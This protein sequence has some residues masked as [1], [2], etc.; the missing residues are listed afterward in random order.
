MFSEEKKA[1]GDVL[2]ASTAGEANLP[3]RIAQ[4][5]SYSRLAPFRSSPG[6]G[7]KDSSFQTV[8]MFPDK[9]K[10]REASAQRVAE[11]MQLDQEESRYGTL[12]NLSGKFQII[13]NNL[14]AVPLKRVRMRQTLM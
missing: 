14:L 5:H 13:F 4:E 6:S 12:S 10:K 2:E 7:G 11:P 3:L 1:E 9:V 8:V